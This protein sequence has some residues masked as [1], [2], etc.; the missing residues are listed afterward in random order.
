MTR[1]AP[2][3]CRPPCYAQSS[4]RLTG[5]RT[6][7]A[8]AC[9]LWTPWPRCPTHSRCG[10]LGLGQ[11]AV[12]GCRSPQLPGQPT[13]WRGP[14]VHAHLSSPPAGGP[15]Q[16]VPGWCGHGP[17]AQGEDRGWHLCHE[18]ECKCA[19][20]VQR[21]QHVMLASHASSSLHFVLGMLL[22]CLACTCITSSPPADGLLIWCAGHR[23]STWPFARSGVI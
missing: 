23:T 16:A 9:A 5:T 10:R 20:V 12:G 13:Q 2:G 15:F 19:A 4:R 7:C 1:P 18:Q 6:C 11:W 17:P 22:G 21:Q 8:P 14:A 3:P